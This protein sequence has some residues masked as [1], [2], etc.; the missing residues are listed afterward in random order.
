VPTKTHGSIEV[1][2]RRPGRPSG[3][4]GL[5]WCFYIEDALLS[6]P[7]TC[8][9]LDETV[10]A[11]VCIIGGGYTGLWTAL[12]VK[13][14]DPAASVVLLEADLCGTGASGRNAGFVM[15]YWHRAEPLQARIGFDRAKWLLDACA[16]DVLELGTFCDEHG[17]DAEYSA[18]GWLWAS[19]T[20]SGIG[21]WTPV[22]D[23]MTRFGAEPWREVPRDEVQRLTG[24]PVLLGGVLDP[25]AGTVQPAKLARGLM[26]VALA[27]GVSV[28]EESPVLALDRDAGIA[29]TPG[30]QVKSSTFVVA[31]NVWAAIIP[32]LGRSLTLVSSDQL[33]TEP[34]PR[35]QLE[36][37][38]MTDGPCVTDS[39]LMVRASH[40]TTGGRIQFGH[41]G[42][43]LALPGRL[44][45]SFDF[46][47]GRTDANA[48]EVRQWY[49]VA[50]GARVTHAWAG[51][52]DRS[53]DGLPIF[54]QL[55]GR[56]RVLYGVGFSGN[57]VGPGR[58]AGRILGGM[59]LSRKDDWTECGLSEPSV[60]YP[61]PALTY[62]TGQWLIRPA[63]RRAEAAELA[64]RSADPLTRFLT[65]FTPQNFFKPKPNHQVQADAR[66]ER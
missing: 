2:R 58:I 40:V 42:G 18:S 59:A 43:S 5:G 27:K 11:D 48:R 1:G 60:R 22:I 57:G 52:V 10:H 54:G 29:R 41:A 64:G 28:F 23:A 6:E 56:A 34:I 36:S 49:P 13:E 55:P 4:G 62:A 17:I 15:D 61:P 31:T 45:Q 39:R 46:D 32:E 47:P 7:A 33:V 66:V 63:I 35:D 50:S 53:V 12:R 65:R 19:R 24:S 20:P 38:G 8:P 37:A 51:G 9:T 3:F 44:P 16:R 14:L 25:N 21:S 30:G 26:R